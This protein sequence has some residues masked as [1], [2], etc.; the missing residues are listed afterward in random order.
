MRQII[1]SIIVVLMVFGLIFYTGFVI[2][3]LKGGVIGVGICLLMLIGVGLSE[4]GNKK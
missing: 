2:S 3:G 4:S 1:G